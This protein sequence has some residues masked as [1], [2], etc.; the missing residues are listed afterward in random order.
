MQR[1]N[2]AY[3]SDLAVLK[4]TPS[5]GARM[6]INSTVESTVG[7]V[8]NR[9]RDFMVGSFESPRAEVILKYR[10]A[11]LVAVQLGLVVASNYL[12]FALRFDGDVP[13]VEFAR[14]LDLL[15]WVV[16]VRGLA[17]VPFRVYEGL[18]KY[19]SISDLL[20]IFASVTV[21]TVVCGVLVALPPFFGYPRSVLIID[22]L[23]LLIMLLGLRVSRRI[24]DRL[25]RAKGSRR[26]LIFGAGDAGAMIVRDMQD[27]DYGYEP[28]GFID[29]NAAKAGKYIHGVRVLGNRT[30]LSRLI[31]AHQIHEVLI[32]I[33]TID[34]ATVRNLVRL[35]EPF[36]VPITT[37]P[38][39]ADILDGRVNVNQIRDLT[40]EDL[41]TRPQVEL[42]I[43]PVRELVEN[44]C[45]LVT[46][47]GGSIGS[48]LARQIA[49]LAPARLVLYERYENALYDLNHDLVGRCGPDVVRAIIGDVTDRLRVRQV[50]D[51]YRPDLVFHAAAHKHVPLM[52]HNPCE[53]VKNNVFGTAVV[54]NAALEYGVER[55]ILIST[56]KAVN[57]SSVM[58]ATKRIA[59]RIL[60]G[61]NGHGAT[62]FAA[63]RFG[64]VLGSNG[65]VLPR[66]IEQIKAG[67]P[68][69]VTHPE[70]R[71]YFMLIPEAVHLVLHAATLGERNT[72][73]VLDM[74]EQIK[75]LDL[76]RHVIRLA[77]YVPEQ[78]IPITF[79]GLRPGE[80][81][82]EELV[83]S[84]ES[85]DPSSIPKILR[86]RGD[87]AGDPHMFEAAL[88]PLLE[89]ASRGDQIHVI[90][91]L[92]RIV[93]G[94]QPT[95]HADVVHAG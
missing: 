32:A 15:P 56:D 85:A 25:G 61:M 17:F 38:G 29:D 43:E 90:Q 28:V 37:L 94:F 44:R 59:E 14:F 88:A 63:V 6:P 9:V 49:A 89:A 66:F 77:G 54:A 50:M 60:H 23:L 7:A 64:N 24:A 36:K 2:N 47:A 81:L 8:R 12:A 55:F 13:A 33:P 48:E 22:S 39:L 10:R 26:V 19:T 72:T 18:W 95:D 58:G 42:S 69:T 35:L 34:R 3:R 20:N 30:D 27:H 31:V 45:V 86:V 41:L 5:G 57:P 73:Y 16:A 70:I 52:E 65:S 71:R 62:R 79:I 40:I 74:G 1:R 87:F 75:L 80:K 46:G 76:A 4:D 51:Q 93:P 67:G 68:V 92:Q 91:Q 11:L 53:A 78:E 83:G 82:A 84:T 21:G